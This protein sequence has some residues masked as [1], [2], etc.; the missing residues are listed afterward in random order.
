MIAV[1]IG[2]PMPATTRVVQIEPA[3]MPTFTASTPRSIS[4]S[5][6]F[7][8]RHVAGDELDVRERAAHARDHVEHALRVAVRGVDDEHV[9]VRGD[10]RLGALHRVAARC[11]SPRRSAAGRASPCTR[12]DT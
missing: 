11:R 12:S 2:T 5:V 1:I 3:P 10:Q 6:A 7:G 9:D 4:A 8:G